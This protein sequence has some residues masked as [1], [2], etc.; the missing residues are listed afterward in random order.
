LI[1]EA[2]SS[3]SQRG[4]ARLARLTALFFFGLTAGCAADPE[5]IQTQALQAA[6]QW[7]TQ[8]SAWQA[9]DAVEPPACHA[10]G[11]IKFPD[12]DCTDMV[13]HAGRLEDAS[14]SIASVKLRECFGQGNAEVCGEFAEIWFD[15][16]TEAGVG[17]REGMVL[18]R[19][20][21]QFRMYWYRSDTLFT[22]LTRRAEQAEASTEIGRLAASQE[23]LEA[24][25]TQIVERDPGVYTYPPC[26]D[27]RVS[28]AAMVGDLI[29]MSKV[30]VQA[31]DQRDEQ[32]NKDLC[33]ALVGK[34]I[35][36]LCL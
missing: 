20:N 35:A 17:I 9:E 14:R 24:A 23:R 33:L 26:I 30:T 11:L 18:K 8:A 19:D 16:K 2:N 25:Y 12:A 32:C 29:A 15:S 22:E 31:L 13:T 36:A 7:F 1:R 5:A 28:S 27:A 21:E 10:F 3:F 4:P 6:S 34:R